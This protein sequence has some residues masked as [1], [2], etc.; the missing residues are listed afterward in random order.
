MG[1]C[2]KTTIEREQKQPDLKI[3]SLVKENWKTVPK[4]VFS[5]YITQGFQSPATMCNIC[6]GI[7]IKP[8]KQLNK[9]I[10]DTQHK[11]L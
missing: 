6:V 8:E 2:L 7:R 1:R 3:N 5:G 10:K 4:N 11:V 9:N